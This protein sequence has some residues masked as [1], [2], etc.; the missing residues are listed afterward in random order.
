MIEKEATLTSFKYND[1]DGSS[2]TDKL[3]L[4]LNS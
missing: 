3:Y 2:F 4:Y 1:D